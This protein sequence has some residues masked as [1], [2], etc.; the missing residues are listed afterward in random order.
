MSGIWK[1]QDNIEVSAFRLG[2]DVPRLYWFNKLE[3]LKRANFKYTNQEYSIYLF[4]KW[5]LADCPYIF[6]DNNKI[7][8]MDGS[9]FYNTFEFVRPY[10]SED[11]HKDTNLINKLFNEKLIDDY[12]EV[13]KV[14]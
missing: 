8:I 10:N 12:F 6:K 1:N 7:V 14:M 4:G 13:I 2:Y 9:L 3:E 11:L 5:Y